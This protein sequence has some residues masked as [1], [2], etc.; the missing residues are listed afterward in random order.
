M[1]LLKIHKCRAA[2]NT[3]GEKFVQL[4][5][6]HN[7]HISSGKRDARLVLKIIKDLSES[8]TPTVAVATAIQSMTDNLAVQLALPTKENLNRTA[9]RMRKQREQVLPVSPATRIFEIHELFRKFVRFDSGQYDHDMIFLFGDPEMIR[10]L[11]K[12]HFCL[13]VGT[14]KITPKTFYHLYSIPVINLGI[15]PACIYAFSPNETE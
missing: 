15:A 9:Q 6:E 10:V 5:G 14:F 2:A 11:E 7:H 13:S 4:R 12:L 8:K 1:E 3:E